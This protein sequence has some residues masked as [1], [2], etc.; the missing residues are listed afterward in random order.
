MRYFA[1]QLADLDSGQNSTW[2][3]AICMA[4]WTVFV[5]RFD[6]FFLDNPAFWTA[7]FWMSAFWGIDFI[8][9]ASRAWVR[10]NFEPAKVAKSGYKWVRWMIVLAV[11]FMAKESG[12]IGGSVITGLLVSVVTLSEASSILRQVAEDSENPTAKRVLTHFANAAD[13]RIDDIGE[14]VSGQKIET[15]TKKKD[16]AK[17]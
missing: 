3:T 6:G 1:S 7:V 2:I 16:E 9:G 13:R 5:D 10:G 12:M 15:T 17:S 4:A 14:K 8:L 11:G